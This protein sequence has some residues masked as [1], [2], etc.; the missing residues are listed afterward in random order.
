MHYLSPLRYPGGKR[1]LAPYIQLLM[2][3]NG[4]LDGTYAEPYAGGG[5]V[6]LSLLYGEFASH[7]YLNDYDPAIAAF[8]RAVVDQP[9]ELSQR[10][11]DVDITVE[12]WER[13]RLVQEALEPDP[14]DLAFSTL[15]L[16]RTNRSG[17]IRGGLIGGRQQNGPWRMD[18]RFNRGELIRRIKKVARYRGR[19]SVHQLDALDFLR[20]IVPTLSGRA[21]LYLDPPYYVKG[22]DLYEHHYQRDDHQRVACLV[23]TIEQPWVVS[24]DCVPEIQEMYA[25]YRQLV[26]AIHYSAQD[27]YRGREVMVF[28]PGL[29]VPDVADPS[30]VKSKLVAAEL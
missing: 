15:F 9:D 30:K 18:A 24:Y 7:V 10:V 12:E 22:G 26:Y 17:I 4:L 25:G 5:S 20:S 14:L 16:N 2:C 1:K 19:I 8:W 3:R 6:A 29:T 27:R 23:R 13:Q 11:W 21:L 28:S